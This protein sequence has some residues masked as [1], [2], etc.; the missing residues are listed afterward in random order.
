MEMSAPATYELPFEEDRRMTC[1]VCRRRSLH[2]RSYYPTSS[3]V[4]ADLRTLW[5]VKC[6]S[7]YAENS[8]PVIE[9]YY[10]AVYGTWRGDRSGSPEEF[11]SPDTKNGYFHRARSHVRIL[12]SLGARY[13]RV[14]DF[15]AGHGA[16]LHVSGAR[17]K[18]AV[19]PDVH[20][21]PYL[22]FISAKTVS[23]D[24]VPERSIDVAYASHSLEHLTNHTLNPTVEKLI[25]ALRVGGLLLAEVPPG[26]FT[27]CTYRGDADPHTL[28]FSPEGIRETLRRKDTTVVFNKCLAPNP[29]P[30]RTALVY[31][32]GARDDFAV[33]T[34]GAICVVVK[35]VAPKRSFLFWRK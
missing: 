12:N 22:D 30:L 13:N 7:G 18:F 33:D 31:E 28:F 23:L 2:M 4:F 24:D 11:F 29:W 25:A 9:E 8:E 34:R 1:V 27:R 35:K 5:C 10:G 26:M 3:G 21:K 19:E 14:L 17:E 15:G 20:C 16:F 32:P 6:G